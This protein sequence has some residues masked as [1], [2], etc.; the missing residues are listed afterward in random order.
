[1]N[2]RM[3]REEIRFRLEQ[4]EV[5]KLLSE[6]FLKEKVS[7]LKNNLLFTVEFSE[8]VAIEA[9]KNDIVFKISPKEREKLLSMNFSREPL[10]TIDEILGNGEKMT[11]KIEVDTFNTKKRDKKK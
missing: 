8:H 6:G 1:M 4:S 10:A 9:H 7:L 5:A 2:I 11:F 3:C